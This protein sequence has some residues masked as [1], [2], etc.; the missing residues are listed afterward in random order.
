MFERILIKS[1]SNITERYLSIADLVDMMFYYDE[2]HVIVSQFELKQLLVVFGE[3]VLYQ[4][5]DTKRLVL[6]PCGQ[7]IGAARQGGMESV[8]VF[9]YNFSTIDELLFNF[10]KEI[11][12]DPKENKRFADKFSK[13]LTEFRYTKDF[14]TSLY[15]DVENADLLT[16]AT[17]AFIRQYY[18]S[19]KRIEE[20]EVIASPAK[21]SFMNFYKIEGNLRIDELN[22]IHHQGGYIG[23][24]NYST[25]LMSLG[26]T[27]AD[28]FSATDLQAELIANQ[29]WIE[30]YKLRMNE[31][32]SRAEGSKEKIDHF[33]EMTVNEFLSPGTAFVKGLMSPYELLN[34]ILSWDTYYFK[35]WLSSIPEGKALTSELY[36]DIQSQNS[37]K[38]WVKLFRSIM[39]VVVGALSPALGG[40]LTFLDGFVGDRIVNGWKPAV[41]VTNMLSKDTYKK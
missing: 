12:D 5:I 11:V 36:K 28:C 7:H 14:Q 29:R 16:H 31:S 23:E 39:Q 17:Q 20:V 1:G 40:G 6:H 37:N 25:I 3:D 21:V 27:H 35:Q 24:F 8:G 30:I 9:S 13:L 2:V 32:L 15:M 34:D 38:V 18:P 10:H 4:L 22:T 41:F 19:Y 33:R 26:E